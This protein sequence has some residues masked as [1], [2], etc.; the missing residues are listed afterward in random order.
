MTFRLFT[1]VLPSIILLIASAIN[2]YK[3][4]RK[5]VNPALST[6]L[7]I[8]AASLLSFISYLKAE[9]NAFLSGLLNFGDVLSTALI[10]TTI[11]FFSST[12]I[13]LKEFEKYYLIGLVVVVVF[14]TLSSNPFLS[15]LLI[16]LLLAMGYIPTIHHLIKRKENTESF[17]VWG[18]IL[19]A[20]L[21]SLHPALIAYL[22]KGIVL[23]L[24]YSLRAIV[25]LIF[26]IS[27]MAYYAKKNK[28]QF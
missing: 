25:L 24:V 1:S 26:T 13:K 6:W 9:N 7:I 2:C 17:L 8:L 14:W 23:S 15:N 3:I 20:S 21:I 11:I 4:I 5:E 10:S 19:F 12:Q 27:P 22:E 16:Q 28:A 18:L